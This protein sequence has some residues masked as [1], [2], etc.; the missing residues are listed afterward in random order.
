MVKALH[1]AIWVQS[2]AIPS[3]CRQIVRYLLYK[4]C[5]IWAGG[6]IQFYLFYGLSHLRPC[7]S[8][9]RA[10]AE[11]SSSA[12]KMQKVDLTFPLLLSTIP[13]LLISIG[14][15]WALR[16]LL[17][18]G[19]LMSSFTGWTV[20]AGSQMFGQALLVSVTI[21]WSWADGILG[22]GNLGSITF[23]LSVSPDSKSSGYSLA[24]LKGSSSVPALS[25]TTPTLSLLLHTPWSEKRQ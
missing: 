20:V 15:L 11:I 18:Y 13:F 16:F 10:G 8:R 12:W 6:Y 4:I 3:G 5:V 21:L 19:C 23:Q 2:L 9:S 22:E 24:V 7:C 1:E 25:L 17:C 14:L